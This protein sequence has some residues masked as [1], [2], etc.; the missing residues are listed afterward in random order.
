MSLFTRKQF[1]AIKG[2]IHQLINKNKNEKNP[3]DEA[4]NFLI[5]FINN[6]ITYYY[7]NYDNSS[8]QLSPQKIE[9]K[10]T[11]LQKKLNALK[12]INTAIKNKPQDKQKLENSIQINLNKLTQKP[13]S[14]QF[15]NKKTSEFVDIDNIT[16]ELS[17]I[18]ANG[19]FENLKSPKKKNA[20]DKPLVKNILLSEPEASFDTPLKNKTL[21]KAKEN[22]PPNTV[23]RQDNIK[24][25]AKENNF[26]ALILQSIEH[27][28]AFEKKLLIS[29]KNESLKIDI[30]KHK[31]AINQAI[32]LLQKTSKKHQANI[33]VIDA[34]YSCFKNTLLKKYQSVSE[35]D[36]SL[37]VA[38]IL[39]I[40]QQ[41]EGNVRYRE[42]EQDIIDFFTPEKLHPTLG[43]YNPI[44]FLE[45][46]N[47]NKLFKDYFETQTAIKKTYQQKISTSILNKAQIL[48]QH[49]INYKNTKQ[50]ALNNF[51]EG[52]KKRYHRRTHN[53]QDSQQ[54]RI[55]DTN[56]LIN[57]IIPLINK[58][59]ST[60]SVDNILSILINFNK[61]LFDD[62]P[63]RNNVLSLSNNYISSRKNSH[64]Q[65]GFKT[66]V[67]D[68]IRI[69]AKLLDTHSK[70]LNCL[71][72]THLQKN[73]L[74]FEINLF[75]NHNIVNR[76]THKY[77]EKIN[78]FW[79]KVT[80]AINFQSKGRTERNIMVANLLN[81]LLSCKS[82][83]DYLNLLYQIVEII[84]KYSDP[85][86]LAHY[87]DDTLISSLHFLMNEV[88]HAHI[89]LPVEKKE[90]QLDFNLSEL[91]TIQY[92]LGLA[93]SE[94]SINFD[95]FSVNDRLDKLV[96][97]RKSALSFSDNLSLHTPTTTSTQL[98]PLANPS[99]H[100]QTHV[101]DFTTELKSLMK[102]E[103]IC[104]W[105]KYMGYF[106]LNATELGY[107][108]QGVALLAEHIP[109]VSTISAGIAPVGKFIDTS[110]QE[111]NA[112]NN[113]NIM[114]SY[115]GD[116]CYKI[117][118]NEAID[119]LGQLFEKELKKMSAVKHRKRFAKICFNR[120]KNAFKISDPKLNNLSV[121]E[122]LIASVFLRSDPLNKILPDRFR[123]LG[124]KKTFTDTY[125]DE[126]IEAVGF[127]LN[128]K[129]NSSVVI[130]SQLSSSQ[131]NQL[132]FEDAKDEDESMIN[133]EENNDHQKTANNHFDLY[134]VNS[135]PAAI[136]NKYCISE[137]PP[138]ST[139]LLKIIGR[140]LQP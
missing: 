123:Q 13:Y 58:L 80:A 98:L 121:V 75:L 131:V 74:Y 72:T 31:T 77:N 129:L 26:H 84:Q 17:E 114:N 116:Y 130:Q 1:D 7:G 10:Y 136:V 105:I 5:Q 33:Q 112:K 29:P 94:N 96:Q 32:L 57:H 15:D 53:E 92:L 59:D 36:N 34:I 50:S 138:V 102:Y 40:C 70:E 122:R 119:K 3:Y 28:E 117:F 76:F 91:E 62:S 107:I 37:S 2:Y 38:E 39:E 71:C 42:I 35:T 81:N 43:L 23:E 16:I 65:S 100:F 135:V 66:A 103:R 113:V 55:N 126:L 104:D 85:D 90:F 47:P 106:T 24:K 95:Q 137:N 115:G 44:H 133:A 27:I 61:T 46:Q 127:K 93:V 11:I 69:I 52:I 111:N 20:P 83:S 128:H 4:Y 109:L 21:L 18:F 101:S 108:F 60:S 56:N 82:K 88:I 89:L 110:L 30:D 73:D 54:S 124:D 86:I 63:A 51:F 67:L 87:H 41:N 19:I 22:T 14:I 78:G 68:N 97:Q 9:N 118:V 45:Y 139:D 12:N 6:I 8:S 48:H 99:S 64:E 134:L 79:G 120:M 125:F 140:S 49:L 25:A 132:D